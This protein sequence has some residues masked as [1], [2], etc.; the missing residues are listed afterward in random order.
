[1]AKIGFLG[2]G[3]MGVGMAARLIGAGH[4]LSVYNRTPA[5]VEPLIGLG[6]TYA[7][8]PRVAAQNAEV[9]FAM[10]SDDEASKSAWLGE[11][12]VLSAQLDKNAVVVEC[13]TLSYQWVMN[14]AGRVHQHQLDYLDC[15]V[16]GL[17]DEAAKGGL[18]LFLG[19]DKRIITRVKPLLDVLSFNQIHFGNVGS[20]T[21]YKLLVNLMGSIQIAAVAEG[22]L[23][24][25]KAGLD[26][27]TV[28]RALASGAAAS[29]QVV[30]N[31]RLM[32]AG[33][34]D[35]NIS[36]NGDLRLKDTRY[37]VAFAKQM[38]VNTPLGEAA[39]NS[40]QKSVDAGFGKLAESK[41]I[42]ALRAKCK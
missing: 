27:D 39:Q 2:T 19:A 34:F 30:R 22:L 37:G 16:T 18:T 31:S 8:T 5:K 6:A 3:K 11:Q 41:V 42:D 20:A 4:Q 1:M 28:V 40:F 14:L 21:A 26:L 23:L 7:S 15:P 10:L 33:E 36:F 25:E 38:Q 17:P 29:P 13:S 24:A 35:K 32:V 12:G 9:V